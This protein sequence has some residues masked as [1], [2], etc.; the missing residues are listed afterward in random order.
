MIKEEGFAMC[1]QAC[2]E[3]ASGLRERVSEETPQR[4]NHQPPNHLSVLQLRTWAPYVWIPVTVPV[5]PYSVCGDAGKE[6][7]AMRDQDTLRQLHLHQHRRILKHPPVVVPHFDVACD[8]SLHGRRQRE[9]AGVSCAGRV[10]AVR[11]SDWMA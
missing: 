2:P 7:R 4:A 3:T 8:G 11:G 6:W 1:R 10:V 9:R 5:W